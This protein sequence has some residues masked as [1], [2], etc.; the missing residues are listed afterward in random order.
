AL[1]SLRCPV[2][3]VR[4]PRGIFNQEPPLFTE[5][6]VERWKATVPELRSVL[7][8]DTNHF[9]ILLSERGAKAVARIIRGSLGVED[10]G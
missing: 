5:A 10:V 3:F 2:V 8:P 9:T 7:V 4:A 6:A 1:R